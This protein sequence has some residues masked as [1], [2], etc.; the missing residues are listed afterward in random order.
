[1]ALG[2]RFAHCR[3]ALRRGGAAARAGAS[4]ATRRRR[5]TAAR[6]DVGA[7]NEGARGRSIA[8]GTRL[9]AVRVRYRMRLSF[10]ARPFARLAHRYG[11]ARGRGV[12]VSRRR[13]RPRGARC[14]AAAERCCCAPRASLRMPNGARRRVTVAHIG[15]NSPQRCN[16]IDEILS[17]CRR[18]C[19]EA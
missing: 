15:V 18:S 17:V 13:S 16:N 1:M 4:H 19:T 8:T 10:R 14:R 2:G 12:E 5:R 7:G 9:T 6:A 3:T 11:I